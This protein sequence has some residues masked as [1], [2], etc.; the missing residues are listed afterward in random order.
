MKH[1]N[2]LRGTAILTTSRFADYALSLLRNII[3]ARMLSKAEFG[4]AMFF[5]LMITAFEIIERMS[6]GK[7]L[8]QTKIENGEQFLACS[9]FFQFIAGLTSALLILIAS[10]FFASFVDRGDLWWAFA[11][12]AVI[13]FLK[14]FQNLSIV[15]YQR[16]LNFLPSAITLVVPQFIVVLFTWP[17]VHL[18]KDFTAIIWLMIMK[19]ILAIS[20]SHF[21]SPAKYTWSAEKEHFRSIF[22]FSWPLLL[23]GFLLFACQQGDKFIVASAFSLELLAAYGLAF[24]LASVPMFIGSSTGNSLLLPLLSKSQDDDNEFQK[25]LCTSFDLVV[26]SSIILFTPLI[27]GSEQILSLL[28]GKEYVSG[29]LFLEIFAIAGALKML[30]MVPNTASV[31]KADTKAILYSNIFRN[32]SLAFVLFAVFFDLDI[33][34][35]A[36]SAVLGELIS[37]IYSFKRLFQKTQITWSDIMLPCFFVLVF[38]SLAVVIQNSNIINDVLWFR[39]GTIFALLVV[40]CVLASYFF[41]GVKQIKLMLFRKISL[42]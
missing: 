23:N 26:F 29:S 7:Q 22:H 40:F 28:Y 39:I 2:L 11:L 19:S 32:S 3:L 42:K 12:L 13:P 20:F 36:S 14:G 38:F 16:E 33:I 34:I 30:R 25:I 9:H 35:I 5:G 6:F 1:Q 41:P 10:T 8:I 24:S 15:R 27:L 21:L 37:L 17:M 31:A 4:L 18:T